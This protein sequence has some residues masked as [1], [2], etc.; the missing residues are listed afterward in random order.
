MF[1]GNCMTATPHHSFCISFVLAS[2]YCIQPSHPLHIS[3]TTRFL[4][5]VGTCGF[6][7][8]CSPLTHNHTF[9]LHPPVIAN[10]KR[11]SLGDC[12]ARRWIDF[13]GFL[14]WA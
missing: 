11:L 2:H 5:L 1:Q 14:F 7:D 4:L 3:F 8:N 6:L 10:R 13:A 9:A 12:I